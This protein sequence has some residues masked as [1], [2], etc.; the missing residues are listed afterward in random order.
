MAGFLL[1]LYMAIPAAA[2]DFQ[3]EISFES[4]LFTESPTYE[5]QNH[6]NSSLAMQLELYY[7]FNTQLNFLATPFY[8]YDH[9]DSKRTH[10][11]L[12]VCRFLYSDDSWQTVL[13][14][15][16]V[17]WGVTE[18]VHLVDII[19]QTDGV[20]SLD[21]EEKLGQ[22]MMHLSFERNWGT[23]DTF[24]LPYF[25][26]RT[27]PGKAGRLRGPV[28]N[29]SSATFESGDDEKHL[30]FALRYSHFLDDWD[31]GLSFF[32]GTSREPYFYDNET[33]PAPHYPIITQAG[34]DL[35]TIRQSWLWKL[36]TVYTSSDED[37]GAAVVLGFEYSFF[38]FSGTEMDLGV[39]LEYVYDDRYLAQNT[40]YDNDVIL[41]IRL[42]RNDP[43]ASELLLGCVFDTESDSH[44]FT[45]EASRR[46]HDIFKLEFSTYLFSHLDE[47]QPDLSY[48]NESLVELE[49]ILFF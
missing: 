13:G 23:I 17:F 18:F 6:H 4:Q 26:E 15:D 2:L 3:G 36:E 24:L 31:I 28:I 32:R 48:T 45:A 47:K 9:S 33:S 11:D 43:E 39:I 30:D 46:L 5:E 27:F 19:N 29:A 38:G 21:G 42:Q 16:R 1:Q 25:R 44:G 37:N 49:L 35:Q 40:L 20:E 34:I 7:E 41:G 8:R 12:R 10:G 22:P 14:I